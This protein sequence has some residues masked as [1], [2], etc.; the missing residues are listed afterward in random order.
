MNNISKGR[1]LVDGVP[2]HKSESVWVREELEVSTQG[3]EEGF[4][5]ESI[6]GWGGTVFNS[7]I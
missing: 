4:R 5:K 3:I 7:M 1:E 6:Q 2:S